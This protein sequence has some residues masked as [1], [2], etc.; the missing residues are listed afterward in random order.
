M[1]SERWWWK[2]QKPWPVRVSSFLLGASESLWHSQVLPQRELRVCQVRSYPHLKRKV[3]WIIIKQKHK[4]T[5]TTLPVNWEWG[6]RANESRETKICKQSDRA[7]VRFP[8]PQGQP[9]LIRLLLRPSSFTL[10]PLSRSQFVTSVFPNIIRDPSES[11][12][13]DCHWHPGWTTSTRKKSY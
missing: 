11:M 4:K 10:L 12:E 1:I 13:G 6:R 2:K 7:R 5:E 3:P 8:F 9:D